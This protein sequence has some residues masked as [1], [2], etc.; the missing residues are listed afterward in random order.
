MSGRVEQCRGDV[1]LVITTPAQ[2]ERRN[3]ACDKGILRQQSF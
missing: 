3:N 1:K 2:I